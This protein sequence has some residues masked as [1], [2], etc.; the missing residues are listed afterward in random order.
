MLL[1]QVDDLGTV[2]QNSTS[3]AAQLASTLQKQ[4]AVQ[5]EMLD[6]VNDIL[7]NSLTSRIDSLIELTR[8]IWES[9]LH[10]TQV[11][12]TLGSQGPSPDL[13]HTWLQDPVRLEDPLGRYIPIPSEYSFGMMKAVV[14][15]LFK[16]GPG[17]QTIR[18]GRYEVFNAH[19]PNQILVEEHFAGFLPGSH[20]I[21]AILLPL[22]WLKGRGCLACVYGT[23]SECNG[24]GRI[25]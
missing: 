4:Q 13:R 14:E 24:G 10:N 6:K 11:L 19:N 20:L 12:E 21:M 17:A 3:E 22:D 1:S 8:K 15:E 25:W 7:E 23:L 2:Q 5:K 18:Y 16:V 9:N